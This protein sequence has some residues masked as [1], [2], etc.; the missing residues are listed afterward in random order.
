MKKIRK[1]RFT[2]IESQFVKEN[3]S[4]KGVDF[5]AN[6]LNKTR[7]EIIRHAS[8]IKISLS[9]EQR[10]L[11]RT[12]GM[13]KESS[14]YKVNPDQFYDIRKPEVAY[15]L[16]FLW[17]DGYV[18]EFPRK[19][20]GNYVI[21][22]LFSK[23]DYFNIKSVFDSLGVWNTYNVKKQ[24]SSW[25]DSI[26]VLTGNKPL[27]RFLIEHDFQEKSVKAPTKILSKIP[28]Y[29]KH[30]FWRGYFDGDGHFSSKDIGRF[31]FTS[32]ISQDWIEH[33][34]ILKSIGVYYS[35]LK[36]KRI[37]G[38]SSAIAVY[39]LENGFKWGDYIYKNR[40]EDDIG[41]S[42]KFNLW[43]EIKKIYEIQQKAYNLIISESPDLK[44]DKNSLLEIIKKY[45]PFLTL[46]K[47]ESHFNMK[48]RHVVALIRFL[49]DSG[50]IETTKSCPKRYLFV[51]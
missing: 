45:S 24:K 43:I 13:E 48:K 28:E 22:L 34:N 17:A 27:V 7:E 49:K 21:R 37:T 41:L 32:N 38:N 33:E 6:F 2:L 42:R 11:S 51:K 15:F 50:N 12:K 5:C 18:K 3:Y 31:G 36:I 44:L 30:Y 1:K 29:L 26:L 40:Y 16:G 25:K 10:Y 20:G 47:I 14:D 4:L 9:D 39:S 8:Y 46:A 19:T 35:I 23:D